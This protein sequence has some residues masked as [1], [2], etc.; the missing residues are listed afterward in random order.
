MFKPFWSVWFVALFQ[1]CELSRRDIPGILF[2]DP[3]CQTH[4]NSDKWLKLFQV[5]TSLCRVV[6]FSFFELRPPRVYHDRPLILISKVLCLH[7]HSR[8]K[9]NVYAWIKHLKATYLLI[10]VY[11]PAIQHHLCPAPRITSCFSTISWPPSLI[12]IYVI[13]CK[14]AKAPPRRKSFIRHY[15]FFCRRRQ[16]K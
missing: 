16:T 5:S 14:F 12:K 13:T 2:L 1:K 9:W 15:V 11:R 3:R 8:E 10:S 7:A 6:K 4:L